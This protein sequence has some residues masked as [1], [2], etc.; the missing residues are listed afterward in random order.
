[1]P[2]GIGLAVSP[3]FGLARAVAYLGL[4]ANNASNSNPLTARQGTALTQV[5]TSPVVVPDAT[6]TLITI[7]AGNP[8]IPWAAYNAGAWSDTGVTVTKTTLQSGLVRYSGGPAGNPTLGVLVEPAATNLCLQ[9]Q[10]FGTT[11]TQTNTDIS[12]N[13][14]AAPDGTTT[15]D[16]LTALADNAT[17]VQTPTATTAVPKCWSLWI[18]RK[19]GTGAI[20]MSLDGGST[21]TEKTIT[22]G[23][24][25]FNIVQTIAAHSLVLKIATSGDAV[26]VWGSQLEA[27]TVPTTYIATTTVAVTRPARYETMTG[28]QIG[29]KLRFN[30]VSNETL[31]TAGRTTRLFSDGTRM[32]TYE[33]GAGTPG[34]L[35]FRD[36]S[37]VMGSEI[38]TNGDMSSSTGF[39]LSANV[40]I[41]G[42]KLVFTNAVT[43]N[44]AAQTNKIS[45]GKTY[46]I[47][48][49]VDSISGAGLTLYAGSLAA[50][51]IISTPGTH[52]RIITAAG[53]DTNI[54][55]LPGTTTTASVDNWSVQEVAEITYA[56]TLTAGTAYQIGVDMGPAAKL[57]IDD[58]TAKATATFPAAAHFSGTTYVGASATGAL[59]LNGYITDIESS[60]DPNFSAA[61]VN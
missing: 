6:G 16:T 8:A 47:T 56:T 51:A 11:W 27:S 39:S 19:T 50:S 12:V 7:A 13:T 48:V 20:S 26:Y 32:L 54:Y 35:V 38:V 36:E 22:A 52:T 42:G 58:G 53:T 30:L 61:G 46:K 17:V 28:S 9:S 25:R 24:T 21:Y 3:V 44:Y 49:T 2:I 37:Q 10:T 60:S 40:A 59:G 1:M 14:I 34:L 15:A 5:A 57:F 43:G 23:W 45:Y 33:N 29:P 4:W 55:I 41:T 31:S 18:K